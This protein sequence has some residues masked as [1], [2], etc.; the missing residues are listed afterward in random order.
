M[1]I[2]KSAVYTV[3]LK[4]ILGQT[5]ITQDLGFL[6]QGPTSFEFNV[7]NLK[8][9]VYF[10]TVNAGALSQTKKMIVD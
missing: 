8:S 9:G 6:S 3:E 5:V 7:S 2:V 4:N 10:Y 1:N